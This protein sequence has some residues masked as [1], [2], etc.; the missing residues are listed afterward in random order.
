MTVTLKAGSYEA[1]CP[2]GDHKAMGMD[3]HFTVT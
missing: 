3:M 2:I 1:Y